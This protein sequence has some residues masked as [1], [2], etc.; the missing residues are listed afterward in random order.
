MPRTEKKQWFS[1]PWMGPAVE[2]NTK[3]KEKK[4]TCVL[5]KVARAI[6]A[7]A[8]AAVVLC[9]AFNSDQQN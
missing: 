5:W 9:R 8:V 6:G 7:G 2:K 1:A 3:K 4:V